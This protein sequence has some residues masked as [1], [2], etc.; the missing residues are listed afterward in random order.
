LRYGTDKWAHFFSGGGSYYRFY[1]RALRQGLTEQ[2]AEQLVIDRGIYSE[3]TYLGYGTSGVASPADLE[4]NY[5]GMRFLLGLCRGDSPQLRRDGERY[6]TAY[7]F[8]VRAYVTVEWD[9]S[10]NNSGFVKPRWKKV[11]PRILNLCPMLEH[12]W[13][14][15]QRKRYAKR[16]QITPTEARL[17]ELIAEGEMNDVAV[18]SLDSVCAGRD[19]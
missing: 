11:K 9:E 1:M 2:Q 13:V 17:A 19:P 18:Y 4:A 15:E 10:Y 16:E 12:P 5:R 14:V 7:P 6:E 3:R 8:D